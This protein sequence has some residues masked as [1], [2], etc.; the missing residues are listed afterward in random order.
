MVVVVTTGSV[1]L[2]TGVEEFSL[3]DAIRRPAEYGEYRF[4]AIADDSGVC[5]RIGMLVD[6]SVLS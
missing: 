4:T 2:Y 1:L 6:H 5:G 3:Q